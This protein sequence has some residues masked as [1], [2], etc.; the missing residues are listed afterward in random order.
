MSELNDTVPSKFWTI[1]DTLQHVYD[2]THYFV[3]PE[4]L[5]HYFSLR[6]SLPFYTIESYVVW[7][8]TDVRLMSSMINSCTRQL[9]WNEKSFL[10]SFEKTS[11]SIVIRSLFDRFIQ[12]VLDF[13]AYAINVLRRRSVQYQFLLFPRL[14][15]FDN[16]E[17]KRWWQ[18]R[19]HLYRS[20]RLH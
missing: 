18:L 12:T 8:D 19:H 10:F 14:R 9:L 4:C 16:T 2:I 6:H 5:W 1:S 3:S 7:T 20:P 11:T 15:H 13:L 17:S